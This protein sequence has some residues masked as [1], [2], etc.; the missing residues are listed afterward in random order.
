MKCSVAKSC[1]SNWRVSGW[2][3]PPN[4]SLTRDMRL[5]GRSS[6]KH[7]MLWTHAHCSER[8]KPPSIWF[9]TQWFEILK[10]I[11]EKHVRFYF[12]KE[13]RKP[14]FATRLKCRTKLKKLYKLLPDFYF[15]LSRQRICLDSG[16]TFTQT[17]LLV[18]AM[19][20][21]DLSSHYTSKK[22]CLDLQ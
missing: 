5:H 9:R 12:L 20:F 13:E 4:Q 2:A 18:S 7:T 21:N 14:N 1:C 19:I 22:C 11:H 3:S 17:K 10:F 6:Y 8:N 15:I 16:H